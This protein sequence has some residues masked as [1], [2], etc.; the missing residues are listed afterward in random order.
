MAELD[1][2]NADRVFAYFLA[3]ECFL[4]KPSLRSLFSIVLRVEPRDNG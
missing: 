2:R 3:A 1:A 4:L